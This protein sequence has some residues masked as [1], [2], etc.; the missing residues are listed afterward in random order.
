MHDEYIPN[1]IFVGGLPN[2]LSE[3]ELKDYFIKFGQVKDVRIIVD[4][5]GQSKG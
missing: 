5:I 4:T 1:R 3:N 2:I